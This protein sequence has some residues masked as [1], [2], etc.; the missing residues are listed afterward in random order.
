MIA[1]PRHRTSAFTLIE[2]LTVIAIIG[3]LAAILIPVVASV[4]EAARS[5]QCMSNLRQ[6]ALGMVAGIGD[7]NGRFVDLPRN[8]ASGDG[9]WP[10]NPIVALMVTLDQYVDEGVRVGEFPGNPGAEHAVGIWRCP[11]PEQIR[12]LQWP[13]YPSGWMWSGSD[14]QHLAL[15][16]P[17]DTM[18]V[19]TTRFPVI[20]DRGSDNIAT[21]AGGNFGAWNLGN[22]GAAGFNP[23]QGWH[24][25][26]RLNVAFADGSVRGYSYLRGQPGEFTDLLRDA[27][28]SNWTQ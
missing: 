10:W 13:Y 25:N 15:G 11:T 2:L 9:N 19:P 5:A 8:P 3:I 21:G 18:P 26:N 28:P 22:S 1:N 12:F 23:H 20:A 14:S 7:N 17:V 4:R 16:R 6:I 24:S 27:Q